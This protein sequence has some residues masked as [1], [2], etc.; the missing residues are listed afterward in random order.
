VFL[1]SIGLR[2]KSK[3]GERRREKGGFVVIP[4]VF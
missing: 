2:E 4:V 1:I 3:R